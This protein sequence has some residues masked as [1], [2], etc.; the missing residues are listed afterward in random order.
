MG[1]REPYWR[2]LGTPATLVLYR[3]PNR[4]RYAVYFT[5]PGGIADGGLDEPAPSCEPVIAQT[6]MHRKA[7]EL[8]HR[9]LEVTWQEADQDGCWT[10]VIT[11]PGPLPAS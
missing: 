9:T 4:W 5:G 2:R 10:G 11:N 3:T 1:K 6:A 8:T 7:E